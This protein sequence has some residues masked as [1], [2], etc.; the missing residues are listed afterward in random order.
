M[1]AARHETIG[2]PS[3]LKYVRVK[4]S[5]MAVIGGRS[6][7][8]HPGA[9]AA[10]FNTSFNRTSRHAADIFQTAIGV[11]FYWRSSPRRCTYRPVTI[12]RQRLCAAHLVGHFT[13]KSVDDTQ[14]FIRHARR[15]LAVLETQAALNIDVA[16]TYFRQRRPRV[17]PGHYRHFNA[18]GEASKSLSAYT[19]AYARLA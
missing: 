2:R 10:P 19:T 18:S 17:I 4:E 3:A 16:Q 14:Y 7:D 11:N 9:G 6:A 13:T 1:N 8:A 15:R 5:M 12:N